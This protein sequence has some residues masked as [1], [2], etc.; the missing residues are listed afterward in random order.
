MRLH[1]HM[2]IEMVQ[3]AI[4]L[5]ATVPAALVHALNLFVTAARPL[6]L[7]GTGNGHEGVDGRQRMASLSRSVSEE[8][9]RKWGAFCEEAQ[10]ERLTV[11]GRW[12]TGETMEGA[13]G[14]EEAWG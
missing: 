13:G 10:E 14:P 2:G 6:V 5:F 11:G 1:G 3:G 4:G 7:L 9:G 8:V 12:L